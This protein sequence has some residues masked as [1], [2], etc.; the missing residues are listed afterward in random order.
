MR[1]IF[2]IVVFAGIS[3]V[4]DAQQLNNNTNA[5]SLANVQP[6]AR[7]RPAPAPTPEERHP[8]YYRPGDFK[9]VPYESITE[10]SKVRQEAGN[11]GV[12]VIK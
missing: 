3:C 5:S 2:W 4:A 6:S 1:L 9:G 12:C 11:I 8:F 10:C 7:T